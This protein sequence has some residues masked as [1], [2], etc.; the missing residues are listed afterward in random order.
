MGQ[1]TAQRML[2]TTGGSSFSSEAADDLPSLSSCSSGE[3]LTI[4][5]SGES[6]TING[7]AMVVCGN[8]ATANGTVH[9]IDAVLCPS[10]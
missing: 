8:I 9:L 7:V 6:V 10:A 1:L 5:T 4:A 2:P 3:T